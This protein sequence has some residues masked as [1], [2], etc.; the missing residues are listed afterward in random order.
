M[1]EHRD[2]LLHM[3]HWGSYGGNHREVTGP[4]ATG[5]TALSFAISCQIFLTPNKLGTRAEGRIRPLLNEDSFNSILILFF[6]EVI[7][8]GFYQSL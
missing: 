6:E 3:G 7:T 8:V 5:V 2:L 1:C 4:L